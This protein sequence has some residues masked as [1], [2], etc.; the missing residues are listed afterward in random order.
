MVKEGTKSPGEEIPL[1]LQMRHAR[2][3]SLQF[4]RKVC[5]KNRRGSQ[6]NDINYLTSKK[7]KGPNGIL[8]DRDR[9][10]GVLLLG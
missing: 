6:I 5:Q 10:D 4:T 2:L 9:E 8:F 7:A 3:A 1:A